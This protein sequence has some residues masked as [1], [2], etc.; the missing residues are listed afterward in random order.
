MDY[1]FS[2]KKKNIFA[3]CFS[4]L[5][6]VMLTLKIDFRVSLFQN[7]IYTINS[8]FVYLI[9]MIVPAVILTLIFTYKKDYKFKTWLLPI[10]FG[11]NL[12]LSILTQIAN[13]PNMQLIVNHYG[14]KYIPSFLCSFSM[15]IAIALMFLG[16]L[17]NL[18]HI[19]LLKYGTLAYAVL[20]LCST[21]IEFLN[22]GGIAYIQS[23]P[24]EYPA[25]NILALVQLVSCT[26]FYVG[27]FILT[28]NKK[29]KDLV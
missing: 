16:T 4:A 21:I 11:I 5:Y 20:C 13:I 12:I 1:V 15:C 9:P 2:N 25:I 7:L 17:F 22:V 28:T 18:K 14:L 19:K 27:I 24:A 10:A 3:V 26:L 8:L 23:V 6:I 29:N